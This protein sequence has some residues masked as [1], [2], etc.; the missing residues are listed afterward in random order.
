MVLGIKPRYPTRAASVLYDQTMSPTVGLFI[1]KSFVF[2]SAGD[3]PWGLKCAS[4]AL[5]LRYLLTYSAIFAS[6]GW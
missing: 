1:I 3:S 4:Q 2:L 6:G 5:P